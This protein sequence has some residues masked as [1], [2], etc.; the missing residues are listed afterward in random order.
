MGVAAAGHGI[1]VEIALAAYL[2]AIAANL[3]SAGIRLIPLGQTNAQRVLAALEPIL[4]T[5]THRALACPLDEMGSASFRA[6]LAS[7]R[8][9]L[10]YT[11]LFRC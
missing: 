8:H 3:V 9:E 10:Q 11:R 7:M 6:D 5:T 4:A 1:P 2:Q